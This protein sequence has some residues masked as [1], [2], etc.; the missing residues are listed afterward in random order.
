M[1]KYFYLLFALLFVFSCTDN[2]KQTS[3]AT[4]N[5]TKSVITEDSVA[6]WFFSNY[7]EFTFC[8]NGKEP[9]SLNDSIFIEYISNISPKVDKYI[10]NNIDDPS[11]FQDIETYIGTDYKNWIVYRKFRSK[12]N[13]NYKIQFVKYDTSLML[14]CGYFCQEKDYPAKWKNI[15]STIDNS[16]Y[17]Y[18]SELDN[19]IFNKSTIEM[20]L[21]HIDKE[22]SCISIRNDVFINDNGK[23]TKEQ[24]K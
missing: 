21:T 7:K 3:K 11:S 4:I 1:R 5:N 12:V 9:K 18:P 17:S 13:G 16:P 10:N 23:I 22:K 6:S 24:F 19:K 20:S 15:V 2:K 14:D 8:I